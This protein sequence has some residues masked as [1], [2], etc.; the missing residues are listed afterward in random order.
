MGSG[1]AI[2]AVTLIVLRARL[3][4]QHG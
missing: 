2:C 3:R 4:A 1:S